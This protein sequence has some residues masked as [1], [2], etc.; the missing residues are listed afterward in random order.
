[1]A[2]VL[3]PPFLLVAAFRVSDFWSSYMMITGYQDKL[4]K[5]N[6]LAGAA[7]ALVWALATRPW[8]ASPQTPQQLALLA[9]ALC[10]SG[11]AAVALVSLR[12]SRA[13]VRG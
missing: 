8:D 2:I 4:L 11:Y 10:V 7:G 3:L 12:C 5:T 13:K 1:M 9:A 6:V